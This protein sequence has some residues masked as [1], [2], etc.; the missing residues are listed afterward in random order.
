MDITLVLIIL[1][2]AIIL[3][4]TEWVRMDVASLMILLTLAITGLVS[5]EQ[6]F[7]GF[8]NP[9]VITV[10][11]MFVISAAITNTGA[12][13]RMSERLIRLAGGSESRLVG[14]IMTSVAA[15]SA[16][17][18]NIGSTAVLLP[19]VSSIARKMKL[20]PSRLLIPLAFGSLL[21]GICTLIGTPPNIL[22][23]SLLQQYAGESFSMFAFT[24]V[25]LPI[26]AG[27]ILY[28]VVAGRHLLP[29]R[30][31]GA[32]TEAY[33]VK[34]YITEVQILEKSPLA[35]LTIAASG[36]E[37]DFSLRVR[38]I[39]RSGR[40]RPQPRRNSKLKEGDILFLEGNP[41]GILKVRQA[42]GLSMVPERDNPSPEG[43][44]GE[45]VVVEASLSPTCDLAGK[46]L[47]EVRFRETHG[48]S[49]L[50]IWRR[51]APVVKKVEHVSLMFGDVLLLQGPEEKVFHLGKEH[52][53]LL[54]GGV[55]PVP[56]RPRKA[57]IALTILAVTILLVVVD[58]LPIM[59]AATLGALAMVL[60]RCLTIQEAYDSI[61]WR[62]IVLIA[63]TLPLGLAMQN[64]GA[65]ELLA[66]LLLDVMG[67]WGPW[68]V[69][70]GI[71]L[72]TS[73]LT[74]VMSHAAAAVLIAPIAFNTAVDLGV[75]PKPFFMAVAI[76]ASS[77]FMTPISHQ[78][79]A[80]VMGPGGYH[81]FDYTRV[82]APLNLMV[83]V[84]AT[85]LIP[86]FFPF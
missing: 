42:K 27:G 58:I 43:L 59:P 75:D 25:G 61:D 35:N 79:N 63:G 40:K 21:G 84:L 14:A 64:S 62:I 19:V 44:E 3:F 18:N 67:P 56:Y 11:A 4:A 82:G 57:P 6:A 31:S 26:A 7:S 73:L 68:A 8:S 71:I 72:L 51:G 38:A 53:F 9:A 80:L 37:E 77:C 10:A 50:A 32:L 85:L 12:M 17:I 15:F 39:M 66:R 41:E 52:G 74:E 55:P 34:E 20:S 33:Q 24:P 30:K 29:T 70:A 5:T 1:L 78:S 76:A 83:W 28:M 2:A 16:F 86:L 69:L 22:M 13:G 54:L 23:N 45:M 36:L 46:T 65:A 48:L 47:A 81:F 60:S 49:V